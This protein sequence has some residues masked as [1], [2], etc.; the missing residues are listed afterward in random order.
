MS[1]FPQ[2]QITNQVSTT[3]GGIIYTTGDVFILIADEN[4]N[5]ANGNNMVVTVA[6]NDTGQVNNSNYIVPGQSLKIYSG[7][8]SR[9][10][11]SDSVPFDLRTFTVV[12]YTGGGTS[13]PNPTVCDAVINSVNIDKKESSPGAADG[14]ITVNAS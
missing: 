2:I 14:Q 11:V 9:K 5:P 3:S 13:S 10:N 7:T 12:N 1:L 4:G 8:L 6:Y